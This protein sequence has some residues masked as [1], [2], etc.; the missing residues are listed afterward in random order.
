MNECMIVDDKKRI[1]ITE[2]IFKDY[3]I[4][5]YITKKKS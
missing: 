5:K 4:K 2:G 1:Y 3:L